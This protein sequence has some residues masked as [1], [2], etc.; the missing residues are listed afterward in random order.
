MSASALPTQL[1]YADRPSSLPD[2]TSMLSAVIA[3]SNGADFK[4]NSIIQF[5]LPARDYL[6]PSSMYLRYKCEVTST[7]KGKM[8]GIPVYTPF[9]RSEVVIGSQI[10]ESIADYGVV[11]N[12]LVNTKLNHATKAGMAYGFG[13]VGESTPITNDNLDGR[14][15]KN[16]TGETWSMAAPLGNLLS[17]SEM[18]IPLGMMGGTRVQLTLD[19][20]NNM[21]SNPA[22]EV[23]KI[24][25]SQ[26]ELCID[27]VSFGGEVDA[28]VGSMADAEGNIIIKSQ[29]YN[30]TTQTPTNFSGTQEMVF[31]QRLSSIKSIVALMGRSKTGCNGKYDSVDISNKGNYQFTIASVPYPPRPLN[32]DSKAGIFME[33]SNAWGVAHDLNSSQNSISPSAYSGEIDGADTDV[34]SPNKFIVSVNTERLSTSALLTGVSSQLSPITFRIFRAGNAYAETSSITL[35]TLF[36]ALIIVNVASRQVSVKI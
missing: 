23:T 6:V 12:T 20:I 24:N 11:C 33:M 8:R 13:L 29:S 9:I 22:G 2:G 14:V 4:D 7:T 19:T 21:F 25:L 15:L 16:V 5:D 27:L 31:N 34:T 3:P 32:A 26:V 18:L 1:N 30:T 10:V 35:V 17:N 36:D 28:I